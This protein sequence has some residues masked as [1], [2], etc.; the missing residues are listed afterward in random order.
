M[1]NHPNMSYCMWQNTFLALQQC[2]RSEEQEETPEGDEEVQAR[3]QVIELCAELLGQV[4]IDVDADDVR[5][6][7]SGKLA[8]W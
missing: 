4:G 6:V 3:K 1:S 8:S 5:S 2:A 7:L